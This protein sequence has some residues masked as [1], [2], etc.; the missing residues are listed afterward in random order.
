MKLTYQIQI[1]L[2]DEGENHWKVYYP[3]PSTLKQAEKSY[4]K[5]C[6]ELPEARIRLISV[7]GDSEI[8]YEV[9]MYREAREG[10]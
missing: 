3:L 1:N 6:K 5:V 2:L 9:L 10:R 4:F 7:L 8:P